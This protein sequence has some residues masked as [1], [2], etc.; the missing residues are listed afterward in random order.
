MLCWP[1]G[2][3]WCLVYGFHL[4]FLRGHAIR[5]GSLCLWGH[6]FYVTLILHE[7][8]VVNLLQNFFCCKKTSLPNMKLDAD[9]PWFL[10]FTKDLGD[11]RKN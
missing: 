11:E 9:V 8:W 7:R 5:H 4:N 2:F 3:L 1:Q 6:G 10:I